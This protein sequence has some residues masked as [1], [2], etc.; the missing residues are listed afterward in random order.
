MTPPDVVGGMSHSP[1]PL[2]C[3]RAHAIGEGSIVMKLRECYELV[4]TRRGRMWLW[5][6]L[7]Q[8]L[9]SRRVAIGVS[10][11]LSAFLAKPSAK[12]PLEVRLLRD[13]DDLSLISE[14]GELAPR[15][16]QQRAD[17]RWF[18]A[19]GLPTPWV[20]VDPDGA[21]CFLAWLLTSRDN[22]ALTAT[23]GPLLPQLEPGEVAIE[24]AFTAESHRGLGILPEVA[25][26]LVDAAQEADGACRGIAFIADWNAASLKAGR[27]AGW[28]P[29]ARREE[30]W[31][32]FR[33]TIRFLPLE[34]AT[35][36]KIAMGSR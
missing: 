18:L 30:R 9:Y 5:R 16:A 15:L 26:R 3:R 36:E 28:F 1:K 32:L 11:D 7:V 34:S 27:K 12:I 14:V 22:D 19:S 23:L 17:Q 35:T 6:T 4:R 33:R 10:R 25:T 2:A 20:A 29:Y 21:V 24:G 13:D 31:L 8:R